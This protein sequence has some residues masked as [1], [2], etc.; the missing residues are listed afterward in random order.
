MPPRS[1]Q[2]RRAMFGVFVIFGLNGIAVATWISR[3]PAIRDI[4]GISVAEVGLL[5]FGLSA[6]AVSGLLGAAVVVHRIGA[7][8]A[9]VLTFVVGSLGLGLLALSASLLVS[10][11]L[12]I[13]AMAVF[14]V[15]WSICDVAM[16]VEG[17]QVEREM[18][19]TLMP[20]YHASWS[21]GTVA[22][23]G[24]GA[25]VAYAGIGPAPHIA[26][27]VVAV[28]VTAALIPRLLPRELE[29]EPAEGDEGAKGGF[30][31]QVAAWR[32]PRVLLI[33]VLV[34]GMAFAEGSA[35]DWLA[36][37]MTDDRGFDDAQGAL[38][39][40]V[41]AVA[42]TVGRIAGVPLLDRFGRVPVLRVAVA[43]SAIGLAVV[44][45]VPF[46]PVMVAGV[47][48]WGLGAALGFPVGM[49]AAG[50]DPVGAAA[51]VSAVATIAYCAFL[52][53][54]PVLGLVGEQIGILN[55]LWIVFALIVIAGFAVPAARKPTPVPAHE[56]AP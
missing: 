45:L 39:F 46:T 28:L 16:N 42:M 51:R 19:R 18:G 55:S 56:P 21:L 10:F 31:A 30:R 23:A 50:D 40:G 36:L 22:G 14:G 33:G 47:V 13:A 44:I 35:N 38:V 17:T 29:A 34:L 24:I 43:A 11:P 5:I 4:L 1:T 15:A 8:R 32:E 52:V 26:G 49:S 6:G 7:R 2:L 54:P 53:G 25:A 41:F 3:L 9:M 12:A 48:V 27:V 20:W 37:A